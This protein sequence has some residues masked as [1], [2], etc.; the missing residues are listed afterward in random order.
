MAAETAKKILAAVRGGKKLDDAVADKP[1][2]RACRQRSQGGQAG[3][4][5][6][7]DAGGDAAGSDKDAQR[8]K[9]EISPPFSAGGDPITGVSPG[10]SVAQIAFKLEKDGDVPDDLI[11]LDDGYAV[12][13]LKEKSGATRRAVRKRARHVRRRDARR[14]AGTTL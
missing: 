8:P 4:G 10:Q 14:Q 6:A 12:M 2:Q 9:V 13:Q 11:K 1:P 7:E 3:K 5:K